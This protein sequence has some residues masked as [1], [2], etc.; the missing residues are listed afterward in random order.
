MK[1]TPNTFLFAA[2]IAAIGL[3]SVGCPTDAVY[4]DYPELR[5]IV[6]INHTAPLG[7]S[8]TVTAGTINLTNGGAVYFQWQRGTYPNFTNIGAPTV[9]GSTHAVTSDDIGH[10]IRVVVTRSG[11]TGQ[12]ES[13]YVGPIPDPSDPLLEGDV[14]I[15]YAGTLAIDTV[16]TATTANLT[17][18][19]A[20]YFQW[21]RGT[22]PKFTDIGEPTTGGN[23]HTVTNTDVDHHIRVVVTRSGTTG[24]IESGYVGPV[25]APP[26]LVAE[27]IADLRIGVPPAEI[28]ITTGL[29]NERIQPEILAFG[30]RQIT[31]TLTRGAPG[32]T[33][34]L[35]GLGAMFTVGSGV[36]LILEDIDLRG[37]ANNTNALVVVQNGGTLVMDTDA[38]IAGNVNT[39]PNRLPAMQG[40]GVRVDDGGLFS[41]VAGEIYNNRALLGGGVV[42]TTGGTFN[43]RNGAISGNTATDYG[44]GLFVAIAG[45]FNMYDGKIYDNDAFWS[46][47]VANLGV[48]TMKNGVISYNTAED[49]GG[50]VAITSAGTFTMYGGVISYNISM[51]HAGGVDNFGIFNMRNGRISGNR[52]T[53]FGGG[54][55]NWGSFT[56]YN[57]IISDNI[58]M[59]NG[60][61]VSNVEV[62]TMYDGEISGNR[63]AGY[64][65]GV[66]NEGDFTMHYGEISGNEVV[67]SGGGVANE[68][69]F[70]MYGGKV[71]DNT[72]TLDG[73][74]VLNG[75]SFDM[76]KGVISN[77]AATRNGGGIANFGTL[78][79][80]Y[81]NITGN[82]AA[83]IGG[84]VANAVMGN[85]AM[86]DGA[87]SG[88]TATN[89]GGIVNIGTTTAEGGKIH[90]NTTATDGGGVLNIG[91][92][93]VFN[94]QGVEISGNTATRHGGGVANWTAGTFNM[95][96]GLISDNVALEMGGGIINGGAMFHISDGIIYGIDATTGGNTAVAWMSLINGNIGGVSA[97]GTF[98]HTGF[99]PSR[100]LPNLNYTI[101]V[102][103]GDLIRPFL[104]S[105]SYGSLERSGLALPKELVLPIEDWM[106]LEKWTLPGRSAHPPRRAF[107][108]LR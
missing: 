53:G 80:H 56:M 30:G 50:G 100:T 73:G 28:T 19:G 29:A 27:Q 55:D 25:N 70:A 82:R 63:A 58:A 38:R 92:Q 45:I 5:G 52:A 69:T 59:R 97:Y 76:R 102:V 6:T 8:A 23:T 37:V 21:Q 78:T 60:G 47:G 20:V 87:I 24:Q 83:N 4:D 94:M 98:D 57:G 14:E 3:L 66:Q 65:G 90:G 104:P 44:G 93:A 108:R 106:N 34:Y 22:Y 75:M 42:I 10:Y 46:G 71:Y 64:G 31:I 16:L 107:E 2:A 17:S 1:R 13:S 54:V 79:M 101:E 33:L 51:R 26:R 85:F 95:R 7:V 72:A 103:G 89:G 86:R 18:G 12:I 96:G 77:N 36:T 99:V 61:G 105:N 15:V 9:D 32:D 68:A 91:A 35:A 67:G 48:F 49:D 74:G 84:G 81:G 43:M 39:L 40:G 88:N 41:M 11:T 62:F